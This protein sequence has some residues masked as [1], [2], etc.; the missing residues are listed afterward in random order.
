MLAF[1]E[2]SM[3]ATKLLSLLL[4]VPVFGLLSM[5]AASEEYPPAAMVTYE[6]DANGENLSKAKEIAEKYCQEHFDHPATLKAVDEK[7][8]KHFVLFDCR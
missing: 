4:C 5:T 3:P 2:R 6:A 8:G 7:D 1:M